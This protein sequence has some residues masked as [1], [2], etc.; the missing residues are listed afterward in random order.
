MKSY[1]IFDGGGLYLEIMPTGKKLWRL[2]YRYLQKEKRISFGSYPLVSLADARDA[3]QDAKKLM[4]KDIDPS[5][6]RKEKKRTLTRNAENTFKAIAMEWY[7][8]K[9]GEWSV[10][11]AQKVW[12]CLEM[13]A[14]PYIGARPIGEIKPPELLDCLRKVEKRGALEIASKT[15]QICGQV[16]RYGIQTGKCEWNAADNLSGA[17]KTKRTEHFRAMDFKQLPSFLGALHRNDARLFERTRRAV[18]LSL[19]TFCR[20]IEIRTARW[21]DIDYDEAI[22]TIPAEKMKMNRDHIIPLCDQVIKIL[23]D[24]QEEVEHINSEWVFPSQNKP[25]NPMSDGTVN[26][27]I[28]NLGFG[29]D[30]V[31]HGFRVLATQQSAKN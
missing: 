27:A 18:W 2:K 15:K 9:K 12:R 23:K 26:K 16:F 7:D 19:Y 31:A 4:L 24:Q 25:R 3:R 13:N 17:I 28:K 1:K 5:S 10:G 22:W 30:M 6:E 21:E 14:F 29:K 20:P 11:H 8:I